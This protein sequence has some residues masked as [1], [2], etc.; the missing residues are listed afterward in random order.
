MSGQQPKQ[1]EKK[2]K[3]PETATGNDLLA[4]ILSS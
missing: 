4:F 1:E 3:N 2:K